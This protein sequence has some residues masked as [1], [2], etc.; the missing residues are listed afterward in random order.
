M[1]RIRRVHGWMVMV[2]VAVVATSAC[3]SSGPV[4]GTEGGDCYDN[5]TCNEGLVC[6]SDHCVDL[7]DLPDAA[8]PDAAELSMCTVP[9]CDDVVAVIPTE[10]NRDLDLL[11]VIDNSG[12]MAE[13]QASLQSSTGRFLNVLA[14]IE[15]GLP[16]LHMGVVSTDVG[17]GPFNISGCSG[18]GDNGILQNAPRNAG[19]SP[20]AGQ[21]IS[22]I[23]NPDG[24]RNTNYTG[25][26]AD[27]F[28]CIARLGIDGCG[29]EQP[30]ESALRALDGRN[31]QNAGFLRSNALLGIILLSDEDDCST[32]NTQMFDTSQN[33]IDDPLGPLSSFR[34]FD[35]GVVCDPDNPRTT[36][37]KAD[38]RPREDSA[39]MYPV[40]RYVD[41][42]R[43]LK[44]DP[45]DV[46]VAGII[47]DSDPVVVGTDLNSHPKLDPSCMSASGTAVPGIRLHS[48]LEGFPGRNAITT[49]CNEDV[50]DAITVIAELL[51]SVIGSP[52]LSGP[53]TTPLDCT[54]EDVRF[55]G[56]P[57]EERSE[58]PACDNPSNPNGSSN[59]PCY[60][61]QQDLAT[62]P[63][64][65]TQLALFAYPEDRVTPSGTVVVVTCKVDEVP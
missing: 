34:C 21:F 4:K 51:R 23:G 20:P 15:G 55:V 10:I 36:G 18:Q 59:L 58:L 44:G 12:S 27:V 6:L 39:Y 56:Q 11:F 48:F 60:R 46:I 45:S 54:V 43:G 2:G 19:C 5:G 64:T 8:V 26:L 61:I 37:T 17:A 40:G 22:D 30:L 25:D 33:S 16:N 62:C 31:A 53:L 57:S 28:G 38:C 13:E 1:K 35:F 14:N 41:F 49:I 42:F 7:G 63:D 32:E 52:C 50:S 9:P 3:G 47:G 65:E 24:T 29:F